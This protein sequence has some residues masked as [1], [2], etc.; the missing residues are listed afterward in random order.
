MESGTE[1]CLRLHP[2]CH[3]AHAAM[4][5]LWETRP[6]FA[7]D[8]DRQRKATQTC[9]LLAEKLDAVRCKYWRLRKQQLPNAAVPSQQQQQQQA[10]GQQMEVDSSRQS[11]VSV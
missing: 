8:A 9:D 2:D 3:Y 1:D 10:E 11:T 5:D 4:L 7:L 6:D